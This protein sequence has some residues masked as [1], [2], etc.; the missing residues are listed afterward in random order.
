MILKKRG[1]LLKNRIQTVHVF[2]K[3]IRDDL[4]HKQTSLSFSVRPAWAIMV[5]NTDASSAAM[6][7]TLIVFS[8]PEKDRKNSS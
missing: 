1:F 6:I 8:R 7:S 2:V 4:L 5:D 3:V